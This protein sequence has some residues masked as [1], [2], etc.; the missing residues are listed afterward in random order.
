MKQAT[1]PHK[2]FFSYVQN[3]DGFDKSFEKEIR[4]GIVEDF[5]DGKT[6]S[7]SEL[8]KKYPTLYNAMKRQFTSE[9]KDREDK[10]RKRLIAAIFSTLENNGYK[11]TTDY[12]K[13][14]ACQAAKVKWFNDIP[15]NTLKDLY[16]K[17]RNKNQKSLLDEI[18][19]KINLN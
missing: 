3:I 11:P 8:Y 5:S 7:L 9:L 1:N 6:S 4:A 16:N 18:V 13:R 10:A 15:L 19:S 12:V 2:W 14:V 17:F